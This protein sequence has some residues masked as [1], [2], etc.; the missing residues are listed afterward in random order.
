M[1]HNTQG[2]SDVAFL[3]NVIVLFHPVISRFARNLKLLTIDCLILTETDG[4]RW[5]YSD[6]LGMEL[7][8]DGGT[9]RFRDRASSD[10]LLTPEESQEALLATEA[11]AYTERAARDIAEERANSE[12]AARLEAETRLAQ[13]QA[14][15]RRLRGGE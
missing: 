2:L 6:I 7:W 8:W 13:M 1:W 12:R 14:E 11:R 15:L 5:G 4:R 10:F 9:L 3:S